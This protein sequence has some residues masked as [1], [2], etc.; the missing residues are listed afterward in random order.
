MKCS[1]C[2]SDSLV[3]QEAIFALH[4]PFAQKKTVPVKVIRCEACG[5]EEDDPGNDV[6]IQKELALQ[7]QSSMVNILNYLNEQGYSNASMERSLGLPARTLARWKNDSA[8]VPSAAALAL[9]RIVRTYPWILQV[10][11][12]KFDEEIACSL[13]SHATVE[14]TRMRSLG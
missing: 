2:G 9:M 6:L 4:E 1:Y 8:I 12:A 3:I 14:S 5:F 11:D 10:A 7:K 13:L